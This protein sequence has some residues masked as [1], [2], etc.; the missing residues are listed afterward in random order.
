MGFDCFEWLT[1][2]LAVR[3]LSRTPV[4]I[5]DKSFHIDYIILL[6]WNK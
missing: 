5:L 1:R 4:N 3:T 2:S 6:L